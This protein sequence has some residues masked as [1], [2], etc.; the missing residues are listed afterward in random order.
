M[1]VPWEPSSCSF[2]RRLRSKFRSRTGVSAAARFGSMGIGRKGRSCAWPPSRGVTSKSPMHA[3]EASFPGPHARV[4]RRA[5]QRRRVYQSGKGTAVNRGGPGGRQAHRWPVGS[6]GDRPR[7]EPRQ[8]PGPAYG[9][10][11]TRPR[12]QR[13]SLATHKVGCLYVSGLSFGSVAP[14]ALISSARTHLISVSASKALS[15]IR[16]LA[17]RSNLCVTSTPAAQP[18]TSSPSS[19]PAVFPPFYSAGPLMAGRTLPAMTNHFVAVGTV[20]PAGP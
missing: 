8:R 9:L 5:R 6:A 3:G 12:L 15:H 18:W 14:R 11:M 20:S 16:L 13:R 1:R 17:R 19:S 7:P 10:C 4:A 2:C